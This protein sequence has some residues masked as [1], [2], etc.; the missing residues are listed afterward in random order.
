M[1]T[2]LYAVARNAF[3][4]AVRQPFFIVWLFTIMFALCVGPFLAAYTFS[5]D[6]KLAS[7]YGLS[8]Q[9]IGGLVL[10]AFAASGVVSREIEDKTALTVISKP[11]ARP[12]FVVG[13][14][15]GVAAALALAWWVWTLVYLLALRQGAFSNV[16]IPW[17]APVLIFGGLA[18][19]LGIG[20]GLALNYFFRK[21]FGST[22]A[23]WLAILLP[24]AVIAAAPFDEHFAAEP[25]G[26]LL[27]PAQWL[28]VFMIFQ[29]TMLFAAVAV[30]CSTR[31]GQA[32]TLAI[33]LVVF[34][35][36]LTSDY[37]FGRQL[38]DAVEQGTAVPFWA[39]V[40]YAA[41]PNLQYH[42]L[43][44]AISQGTVTNIGPGFVGL[45]SAYTLVL[46]VGVLGL[47]V[48]LFQTRNAA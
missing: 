10:A 11:L 1:W 6:N 2:Q 45:V 16:G 20:I 47:A 27:D 18:I 32:S 30:T 36:G 26:E 22:A 31:L 25:N 42:W 44:D 39:R 19:T 5:D 24:I 46:I 3:V 17:D 40:G 7:D 41:T 29:A 15:L 9:L 34:L 28:A 38:N 12:I 35:L 33:M 37:A 48:A 21:P 14:Y 23:F 4:E 43:G 8:S 13:K